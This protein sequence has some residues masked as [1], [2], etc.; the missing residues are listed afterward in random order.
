MIPLPK[1]PGALVA[2]LGVLATA[3]VAIQP[4][5][6]APWGGVVGVVL[7]ILT[8]LGVVGTNAAIR[9]HAAKVTDAVKTRRGL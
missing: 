4:Q 1:L 6:P 7:A 3:L 9:A 5:L 2:V 8:A